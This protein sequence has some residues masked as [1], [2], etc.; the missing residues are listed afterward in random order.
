MLVGSFDSLLVLFSFI[1]AVLASYTALDLV[2]RISSAGR[3][4]ARW[5][6]CG[7]ALAMGLGVWSMH[8]VG[9]LAFHLPIKLGFDFGLTVVSLLIAV[10][11]SLLALWIASRDNL[12]GKHLVLGALLLGGG[13]AAM[14]YTGMAALQMEPGIVYIP[15]LVAA[16]VAI[17]VTAAGAALW[18]AFRLRAYSSRVRSYRVGAALV[19]GGAV[20]AMHYTGMAAARF[21]LGSIC[22]AARGGLH[23]DTL[24]LP[25]IVVTIAVLAVVLI[26]S[27]LDL[28]LEMQTAALSASLEEANE[29]LSYL[30]LHDNLTKLPNRVL[31]EE[32]LK[33]AIDSAKLADSTQQCFAVM[34]L[35]LDGFKSVNDTF[36]HAIGDLLLMQTADR[37]RAN[38]RLQDTCARVGGDEFVLIASVREPA[39]ASIIADKLVSAIADPFNV[40]G[41][42]LRVSVSI[43]IALY[44]GDG[45]EVEVLLKNADVAMYHA[46]S[47]GRNQA[48]FFEGAMNTH[49]EDHLALLQDLRLARKRRQF[50][51]H[52]QPKFVAP[53]G[54]ITGVEALLRWNHPTRGLIPPDTFIPIAERTGLIVQIGEWVIDE[55]CRQVSQWRRAGRP[56][57]TMAVNIS[58]LQF[59]NARLV[60]A[61]KSALERYQLE[62]DALTL[63]ITESTAMRDV[64]T[65][66][67]ILERLRALGVR[68]SIDDFGT[69]YSSLLYLKRLPASE[70]K[71]DRGFVSE[72]VAG[73]EDAAIVAAIIALGQTLN[74]KIVAE[75]VETDAQQDLLTRLGCDSL[76]GFLLGRPMPALEFEG[77]G[78]AMPQNV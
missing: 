73:G 69:G 46:K 3:V 21:P 9:M 11:S 6:L 60:P 8:F 7:G 43:G 55:A 15:A 22:S 19:M 71:I 2:G 61:V 78:R 72:L 12:P 75:G 70:L 48:C 36:G 52:Y 18:I 29:E 40:A 68:I 17:A 66:L 53:S 13:I 51:L 59:G 49:T 37:I 47:V 56:T 42:D 65:S 63:E 26:T 57:L 62:G 45:E 34:F 25:I 31:L 10:A 64:D 77:L 30:V 16:S 27:V 23:N 33:F 28:R 76:Q 32:R 1:V 20:V 24:A 41:H 35:D 39:D 14:H 58:A 74:L 67:E 54:P 5:W 44:P 50:V 4:S 38:V